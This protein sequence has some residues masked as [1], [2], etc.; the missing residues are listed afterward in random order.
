M[1][2]SLNVKLVI[3]AQNTSSLCCLAIYNYDDNKLSCRQV[4]VDII[5]NSFSA[6]TN[7]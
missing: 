1:Y 4:P 3:T 2:L 6:V 5:V 7:V